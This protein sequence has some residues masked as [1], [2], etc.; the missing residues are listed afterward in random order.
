MDNKYNSDSTE[1]YLFHMDL[2]HSPHP[3][4]HYISKQN[5]KQ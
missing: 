3:P 5:L 1:L 2:S 4:N